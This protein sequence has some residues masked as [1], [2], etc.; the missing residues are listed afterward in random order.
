MVDRVGTR[1]FMLFGKKIDCYLILGNLFTFLN[2]LCGLSV[3]FILIFGINTWGTL[4]PR[5]IVVS[6]CCDRIDGKFARKSKYTNKFGK[7]YDTYADLMS[8]A[9]APC[10]LIYLLLASNLLIGAYLCGV[11]YFFSS[12]F[13]LS[14]YMLGGTK[15]HFL[16]MPSTIGAI[17]LAI[18][19]VVDNFEPLFV[20]GNILLVSFLMLSSYKYPGMRGKLTWFEW[21]NLVCGSF[22][23]FLLIVAPD[24]WYR[25]LCII[26]LFYLYFFMVAGPI[27]AHIKEKRDPISA[28][29]VQENINPEN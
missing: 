7:H 9:L 24:Q 1:E 27:Y 14:R 21:F 29:P 26:M 2:F 20:A 16:G 25:T 17:L 15:T 5:L 13:R 23:L 6:A 12:S 8:F 19:Y 4:I 22:I 28:I 11:L 3:S 18:F 10:L